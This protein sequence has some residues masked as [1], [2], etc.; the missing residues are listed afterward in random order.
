MKPHRARLA[1]K[2]HFSSGHRYFN[3]QFSE[4]QNKSIFGSCYSQYGHGHNYVLEAYFEGEIDPQ[5][6]MV[7]NL[8]DVDQWLK[9]V[10]SHLDHRHLNEDVPYFKDV[11][12]TTENIAAY[13]YREIERF[14]QKSGVELFKVRLYE[15]DDLW[16][17]YGGDGDL[18]S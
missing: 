2:V 11:I 5:T 3:P 13:L 8:R 7:I 1:R 16:V 6:G 9:E 15:N 17:D 14:A 18:T 10:T 12:P 4:E